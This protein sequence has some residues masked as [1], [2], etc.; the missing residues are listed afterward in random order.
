MVKEGIKRVIKR[1]GLTL[2]A[3][4]DVNRQEKYT[5]ILEKIV[6]SPV[7]PKTKLFS[8]IIFSK[9]RALQLDAL[10]GSLC[11]FSKNAPKVYVLHSSSTNKFEQSYSQVLE[12]YKSRD[13][14]F[15]KETNFRKDLIALFKTID[16]KKVLFLVDD[17]MFK[18][19]IDFEEFSKIDTKKYVA[20]LRMGSHL[21][22]S[23]TTQKQQSKPRFSQVQEYRNMLCW[24]FEKEHLDWAYPL[25][26][27]G[28]LFSTQEMKVL[29]EE[30][31]YKAPNSFE[32]ALQLMN[33][34]YSKRLGLCYKESVIINNPCNKVQLENNNI[35]GQVS[36]HELNDKWVEGLRINYKEYKG[37][38]NES[39]HQELLLSFIE[40]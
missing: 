28:H 30:L 16:T 24:S 12:E 5:E 19:S 9:D 13:I 4:Y 29:V 38:A 8:I 17:L 11:F 39:A 2:I 21:T 27:D 32:E 7:P 6:S 33:P 3:N 20:S 10:L 40:R 36:I 1:F 37:I 22:F 23:Y 31:E 15:I 34:L 18:N 26:V 35:A 14:E 25:S